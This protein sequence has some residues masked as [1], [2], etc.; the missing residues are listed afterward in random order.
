MNLLEQPHFSDHLQTLSAR[1]EEALDAT[2]YS[3]AVVA[4]GAN[5]NYFLDDQGPTYRPNPHFAQWFPSAETEHCELVISPGAD[6]LL[7]FYQPDD[8]WHLP[9]SIP[10]WAN[11][12]FNIEQHASLEKLAKARDRYLA[13]S[14]NAKGANSVAWIGPQ[15]P[16]DKTGETPAVTHNPSELIAHLDFL[17]DQKTEFEIAAMR[18]AT[19]RAV[20]GHVKARDA[21]FAGA[22]EYEIYMQFLHATGNTEGQLPY[23][24]I[25][26]LNEHG[27]VL[28][29][30]H[31]DSTPP[32]AHLSFLI[33]AGASH[34]G[35]ASDITRTY[36][37]A[38]GQIAGNAKNAPDEFA[39]LIDA[40][41][42]CQLELIDNIQTQTP[43]ADLH[44]RMIDRI[45]ELGSTQSSDLQR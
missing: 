16:A 40:L 39:A 25:V 37:S 11:S 20:A 27:G 42:T 9:P 14:A 38:A 35:Y 29:Y 7:L 32:A 34:L 15:E 43:Y 44:G 22:S 45:A 19:R 1:W 28:H 21:F 8:Y 23:S 2:G 3:T 10:Q 33:D 36:S 4:A 12:Q 18:E 30:Q 26:A 24:S 17:R 5:Q 13:S 31:Y 41:D 6:P